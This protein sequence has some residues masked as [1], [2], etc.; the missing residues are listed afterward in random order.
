M[1]NEIPTILFLTHVISFLAICVML[2][3]DCKEEH[4]ILG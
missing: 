1:L 4:E 2:I 3:A